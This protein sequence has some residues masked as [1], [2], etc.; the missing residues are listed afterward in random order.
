MKAQR[1]TVP[2]VRTTAQRDELRAIRQK[3]QREKPS[4]EAAL[5]RS[6][7]QRL[8][9]LGE[10]VLLHHL[11]SQMKQERSRQNVTLAQLQQ[12]T[13]ISAAALSRLENGKVE[14]PTVDTLYRVFAALGKSIACILQDTNPTPPKVTKVKRTARAS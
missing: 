13:G 6:P 4:P 14:N 10:V 7:H 3:Y 8:I 1:V 2:T 5:A 9:P 12:R 11:L